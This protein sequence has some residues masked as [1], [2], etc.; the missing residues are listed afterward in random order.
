MDE[1]NETDDKTVK[2]DFFN[3]EDAGEPE[4]NED[5]FWGEDNDEFEEDD[6]EL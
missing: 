1:L 2:E 3:P 4:D 5:D 6:Y